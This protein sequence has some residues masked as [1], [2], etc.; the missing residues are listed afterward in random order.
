MS[1]PNAHPLLS[2]LTCFHY[3][4]LAKRVWRTGPEPLRRG[5]L[6]S[7]WFDIMSFAVTPTTLCGSSLP[8]LQVGSV[9]KHSDGSR[10]WSRPCGRGRMRTSA[11]FCRTVTGQAVPVGVRV[12]LLLF[13]KHR[14]QS[15][16]SRSRRCVQ[17]PATVIWNMA[18]VDVRWFVK[19]CWVR[20]HRERIRAGAVCTKQNAETAATNTFPQ[21]PNRAP[22]QEPR[23]QP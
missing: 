21:I 17:G 23:V 4:H 20:G 9:P 22:S 8:V 12:S 2:Y 3:S 7:E 18:I 16:S 15:H 1:A 6:R 11:R 19:R 5:I 13:V 14:T 10:V